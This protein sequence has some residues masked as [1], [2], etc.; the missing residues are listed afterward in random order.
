MKEIIISLLIAAAGFSVYAEE[1]VAPETPEVPVQPQ[2]PKKDFFATL[3]EKAKTV[4]A[5][6]K[7]QQAIQ[8]AKEKAAP[9][10]EQLKSKGEELYLKGKEQAG[11]LFEKAKGL[12]GK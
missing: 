5:N 8:T 4:A 12:F 1:P 2:Q 11:S 7:T 3:K 9:Y 6:P 10:A